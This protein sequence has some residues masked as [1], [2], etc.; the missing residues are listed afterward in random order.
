[1]PD[2]ALNGA[3][4]ALQQSFRKIFVFNGLLLGAFVILAYLPIRALPDR[5]QRSETI[6]ALS[7]Q[8]V[9]LPRA[10]GPLHV[11]GAWVLTAGD[12]RFAGLSGL[13]IDRGRFLAVS[14]RGAVVRFDMPNKRMPKAV[15]Q[16]LRIGPGRFG[17]KWRRDAESLARDPR[18]RGWWVGYEQNH[19]L[20]LY[21]DSFHRALAEID[22]QAS[23]WTYNRGAE[24]LIVRNG[25][26]LVLGENGKDAVRIDPPGPH[27]LRLYAD[28][29]VAD[30]AR[31]PD[32]SAWILLREKG[33]HGISQSIAPLQETHDGYLAGSAW[34][35]PKAAFDNFE[36]M[37]IEARPDGRWRFWL[38]T[39]DGHRVLARTLL[40]AL[41][42][43]SPIG[44]DKSPATSAGPQKKNVD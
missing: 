39:D 20:W 14:D 43:D 17:R 18:G 9:G 21:D 41:D 7:Y 35:L 4:R 1:M 26:L 33:L 22:L 24:G 10:Q 12:P 28:A 34:P 5:K 36:G 25:R 16:D 11:A 30:A 3:E 37:T 40:V 2:S 13:A 31:A 19:S 38:V 6:V 15:L 23:N 42:L 29:D 44:H 27:R 8:P 32:G